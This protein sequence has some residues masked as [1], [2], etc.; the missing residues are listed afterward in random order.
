MLAI[1]ETSFLKQNSQRE[2]GGGGRGLPD[3]IN[4]ILIINY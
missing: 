4:P 2:D 3:I 1:G